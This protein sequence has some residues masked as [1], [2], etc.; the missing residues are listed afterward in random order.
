[1]DITYLASAPAS[2]TTSTDGRNS[3]VVSTIEFTTFSIAYDYQINPI[4]SWTDTTICKE[5]GLVNLV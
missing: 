3:D 2:C 1:M 4:Q 5:N